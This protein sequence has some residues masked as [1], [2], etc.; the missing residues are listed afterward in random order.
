MSEGPHAA[1]APAT[2][3]AIEMMTNAA[4]IYAKLAIR[5]ELRYTPSESAD[6]DV[7]EALGGRETHGTPA[8]HNQQNE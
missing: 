2:M 4:R 7:D 3:Q 5:S 6:G 1:A 8:V